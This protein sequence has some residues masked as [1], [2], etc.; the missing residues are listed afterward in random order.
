VTAFEGKSA[1]EF[2]CGDHN[3]HAVSTV[4]GRLS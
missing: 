1:T 3:V 2:L 4:S